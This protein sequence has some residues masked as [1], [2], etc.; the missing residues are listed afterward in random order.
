MSWSSIAAAAIGA[1]ATSYAG[2]QQQ[3]ALEQQTAAQVGLSQEQ[4]AQQKELAMQQFAKE[5][6]ILSGTQAGQ[7]EAL[8][9][10][11]EREATGISQF[12]EATEGSPKEISRLQQIISEQ[13]LPEQQQAIKRGQL[14][15]QQAGVRGP[16]AGQQ[17]AML[18]GRLGRE[19]GF[20]VEKLALEEAMRR[21]RSREQ[22]AGAQA[23]AAQAAALRPVQKIDET[24]I[25]NT[26]EAQKG[27][28][29]TDAEKEALKAYYSVWGEKKDFSGNYY[30]TT[31]DEELIKHMKEIG[32]YGV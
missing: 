29:A 9:R 7:E 21:Q 15:L 6:G 5:L 27:N 23:L 32:K 22:L 13:R 2:S 31:Q 19:L 1:I 4:L 20:D 11:K 14:A 8:A 3:K 25:Q 18:A 26:I 28:L 24:K 12:L 17:T 10:A 16:E 30:K